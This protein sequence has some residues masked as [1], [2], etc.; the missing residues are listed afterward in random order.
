MLADVTPNITLDGSGNLVIDVGA[1]RTDTI[2]IVVSG[3]SYVISDTNAANKFY[4][5]LAT[6]GSGTNSITIPQSAVTGTQIQ[7]L[8]GDQNDKL[9]V[10]FSG[11]DFTKTIVYDGGTQTTSDTLKLT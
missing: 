7:F 11:G 9:T 8:T 4:S 1:G 10:D 6:S 3:S 5:T 2:T